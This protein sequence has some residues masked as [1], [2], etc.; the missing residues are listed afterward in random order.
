[1]GELKSQLS[2]TAGLITAF[3]SRRFGRFLLPLAFLLVFLLGFVTTVFV[4]FPNTGLRD[5]V[6]ASLQRQTGSHVAIHDLSFLPLLTLKARGISWQSPVK[7][8][9][10]V[11]DSFSVS[12]LWTTLMGANPAGRFHASV[13][14]GTISGHVAKDGSGTVILAG[15]HI[16]SILAESSH[17]P[18]TGS[19][20]GNITADQPMD[21]LKGKT[22]FNL[23]ANN[24]KVGGLA[25]LGLARSELAFGRLWLRG[26]VTGQVLRL[27]D[28]RNEGGGLSITGHG[29]VLL[30]KLP[31]RCRLN[32]RLKMRP[33][34]QLSSASFKQLLLLG[35][36][37]AGADGSYNFRLVGT[38]ARPILR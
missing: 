10:L 35:G 33:G 5:Y 27:E 3:I 21:L 8:L 29:T 7:D 24:L 23:E 1:M 37:K 2:A 16:G 13:A 17:F 25:G 11:I 14:G 20:A 36:L 22:S 6:V 12:P 18:V 9:T 34:A 4:Y 19:V 38:M 28:L 31:R 15:V 30:N 32:L 26:T